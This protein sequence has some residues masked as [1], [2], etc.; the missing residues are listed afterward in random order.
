MSNIEYEIINKFIERSY[1]IKSGFYKNIISKAPELFSKQNLSNLSRAVFV[2]IKPDAVSRGLTSNI[3]NRFQEHGLGVFYVKIISTPRERDF[4][5]LYKFN[6][7]LRNEQNMIGSWWINRLLYTA[8]PSVALILKSQVS[9]QRSPYETLAAIKGPSDPQLC[10]RGQIR[11]DFRA[12]NVA[13]NLI[14]TSDD[15]ISSVREFQIFDKTSRLA[16]VLQHEAAFDWTSAL[17]D[18]PTKEPELELLEVFSA[19]FRQ[20]R[21]VANTPCLSDLLLLLAN[22]ASCCSALELHCGRNAFF[23]H[24]A[25][26]VLDYSVNPRV[27]TNG[28][29]V[30]ISNIVNTLNF[31]GSNENIEIEELEKNIDESGTKLSQW[32][33]MIILTTAY[34]SA[35]FRRM[36]AS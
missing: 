14:H 7:T 9:G 11:Y 18:L 13:L 32:Q 1:Y 12:A 15:P 26:Q 24:Y 22:Q 10:E 5:E 20:L 4:E 34:Y 6:L 30:A 33:K 35:G 21:S 36:R 17:A 27:H 31:F 8:G 2:L 23:N 25:R 19:V 28:T 29:D 3:I 16:G